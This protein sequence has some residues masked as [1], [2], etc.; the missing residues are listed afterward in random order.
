[1][2]ICLKKKGIENNTYDMLIHL[3]W[4]TDYDEIIEELKLQNLNY[5]LNNRK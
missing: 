2:W 3:K 5:L 1:M 4:A